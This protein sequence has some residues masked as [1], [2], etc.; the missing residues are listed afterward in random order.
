MLAA[1]SCAKTAGIKAEIE[2]LSSADI[3]VRQQN[4]NRYDVVDTVKTDEAGR[5]SVR[6][7][8]EKGNPDF[9]YL[10][11]G[12]RK[13]A[14]LLL[15]RGDKVK[16]TADTLGNYTSL[17]AA[18]VEAGLSSPEAKD[19]NKEMTSLYL[20]YY[21][22]CIR[23]VQANPFSLTVIPVFY[24]TVANSFYVF[25]QDTDAF[26]FEGICDSLSKVYPDS[27]YVRSLRNE[28]DRRKSAMELNRRLETAESIGFPDI[29]L[30]DM[31]GKKVKLSEV[32]AKVILVH[33]WTATS[34]E[35]KMFNLDVL[36]GIYADYHRKGLEIYQVAVDVDKPSWERTVTAQ[37][38]EWINVCDGLGAASPVLTMYNVSSLP[39]TYI[40]ADGEMTGERV[41]DAASLRRVLNRLLK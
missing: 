2:G 32:D 41:S 3:V 8:M 14:S 35:Q 16:V 12:D 26:I 33:F 27:K 15:E 11:Y 19:I 1:V 5:L 29:S 37:G 38:L 39:V 28:T 34:A 20:D 4:V 13:I 36:K 6:I 9:V 24:Q 30:P 7:P 31:T 23:Y 10:Y 17:S 25:S 40:I 18:L 21:R 22:D